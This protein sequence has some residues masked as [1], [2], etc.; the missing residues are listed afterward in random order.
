MTHRR[1]NAQTP[2]SQ[3]NSSWHVQHH[4]QNQ[5]QKNQQQ[6]QAQQETVPKLGCDIQEYLASRLSDFIMNTCTDRTSEFLS[7]VNQ[8][9]QRQRQNPNPQTLRH[10]ATNGGSQP[11][12]GVATIRQ[13]QEFNQHAKQIGKNLARTFEK[14]EKLTMLC[15]KRTLFDDRPVE[16]QELTHIVK[17]DIDGLQRGLIALDG[18]AKTIPT[19]GRRDVANQ[20]SAQIKELRS[21]VGTASKSFI[22]V[23]ELRRDN[24]KIQNDRREQFQ[25]SS[26]TTTDGVRNRKSQQQTA[27][28]FAAFETEHSNSV[29][30]KD[31]HRATVDSVDQKTLFNAQQQEM[32]MIHQEDNY[33]QERERNME[34]IEQAINEIGSVMRQLGTMV[35]EQQETVLRIDSNVEQAETSI[36]NA[37]GEILKYFQSVTNNRWLMVK[38]FGTL[39]TF[40]ILFIVFFA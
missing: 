37:H 38:V 5:Q 19:R 10:G 15:K 12:G 32:Q 29:L 39:I 22:N 11:G 6:Q 36:E 16:I 24:I 3:A 4:S 28:A 27:Q 1:Q 30:S 9:A 26:S 17:Q 34:T 14:L 31:L 35:A 40:F 21:R 20:T 33:A 13:R 8:K 23:M 2:G 7:V 25:G 18:A